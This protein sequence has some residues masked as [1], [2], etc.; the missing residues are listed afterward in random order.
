MNVD[1]LWGNFL[2][3][4]KENISSLSYET[5]FKDTK[6][7]SLRDNVATIIVPMPFHKK[8]LV[9]NYSSIIENTFTSL[10]D[11]QIKKY[12]EIFGKESI[13]KTEKKISEIMQKKYMNNEIEY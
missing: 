8:H 10:T 13:A 11:N 9:E 3:K 2:D 5:W 1:V 4:I 12:K 7:V 6:L